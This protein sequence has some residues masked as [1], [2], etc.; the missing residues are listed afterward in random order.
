MCFFN[1]RDGERAIY[2]WLE[3]LSRSF[4]E[5]KSNRIPNSAFRLRVLKPKPKL[6]HRPI[7]GEE[8]TSKNR[9]ELKVKPSKTAKVVET[10]EG[11]SRNWV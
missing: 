6:V 11:T 5:I 3:P 9:Y 7:R 4:V 10:R 8:I 2:N 1:Q